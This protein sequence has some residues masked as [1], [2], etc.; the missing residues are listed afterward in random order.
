M[1]GEQVIKVADLPSKEELLSMLLRTIQEGP[2]QV[3]GVI[4]GPLRLVNLLNYENKLSKMKDNSLY[5][6]ILYRRNDT[7]SVDQATV[8]EYIK[9]LKLGEVKALIEVW[10]MN[11][12]FMPLL[13]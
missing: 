13:L 11:L 2:R 10:K 9:N 3:L 6:K 1:N 4:Q 5:F 8:V 12:A 7:M